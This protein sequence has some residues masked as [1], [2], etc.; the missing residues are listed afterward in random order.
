[1]AFLAI[2]SLI[3]AHGILFREYASQE[4]VHRKKLSEMESRVKRE[5]LRS[6]A[7]AR[8]E[9][10]LEQIRQRTA[11]QLELIQLQVEGMKK[12]EDLGGSG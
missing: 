10:E 2:G 7:L 9:V 12:R 4:K 11:D 3:L 6:Q 8:K 5:I 1:M